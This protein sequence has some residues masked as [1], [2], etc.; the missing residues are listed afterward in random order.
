MAARKQIKEIIP[1]YQKPKINWL[2]LKGRRKLSPTP[3][4]AAIIDINHLKKIIST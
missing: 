2:V 3:W 4:K 1:P